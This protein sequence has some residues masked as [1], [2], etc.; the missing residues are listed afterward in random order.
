MNNSTQAQKGFKT[1]LLTLSV[2]LIIFSVI[3]YVITNTSSQNESLPKDVLGAVVEN[4]QDS[5]K[6]DPKDAEDTVFGKL[7]SQPMNVDSK[8]VLAGSDFQTTGTTQSTT[9]VPQT[10]VV[11]ITFGLITSGLLF[12][13]A[14]TVIAKDPRKLAITSFEKRTIK[15]L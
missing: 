13:L 12:I 5:A 4:S 3:Y 14:T 2:S 7:A 1:F 10:G 6:Q 15:R 8:A 9:S 11:G